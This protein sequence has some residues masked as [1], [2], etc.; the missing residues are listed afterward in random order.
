MPLFLIILFWKPSR[1]SSNTINPT[2]VNWELSVMDP[3]KT[4]LLTMIYEIN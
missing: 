3:C 2:M 4:E 1:L